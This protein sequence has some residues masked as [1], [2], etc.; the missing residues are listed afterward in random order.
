MLELVKLVKETGRNIEA[1]LINQ[2]LAKRFTSSELELNT[3]FI[4]LYALQRDSLVRNCT[5]LR[6]SG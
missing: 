6:L 1:G 5:E 3:I 2:I 4:K